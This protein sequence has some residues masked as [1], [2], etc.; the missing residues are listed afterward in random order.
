MHQN[1][2]LEAEEA[3]RVKKDL[4]GENKNIKSLQQ[5]FKVCPYAVPAS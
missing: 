3:E 5:F 1:L 2:F 4:L